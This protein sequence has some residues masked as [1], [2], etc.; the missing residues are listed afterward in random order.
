MILNGNERAGAQRLAQH[1]M[2][3]RDNDHVELYD[4]RGFVADDL[5]GALQNGRVAV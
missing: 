3:T 5:H 4:M 1:L 2:N